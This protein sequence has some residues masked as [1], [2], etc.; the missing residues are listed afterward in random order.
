MDGIIIIPG[1]SFFG[2][3]P[4]QGL[5]TPDEVR[6]ANA[7]EPDAFS[8]RRPIVRYNRLGLVVKYGRGV[9]AVEAC[10]LMMVRRQQGHEVARSRSF[11]M[12]P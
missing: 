7:N 11:C 3:Q 4:I 2:Q 12:G 6:A 1:S 5:P 10:T 8:D 9:S